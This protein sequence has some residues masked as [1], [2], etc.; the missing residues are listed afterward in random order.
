MDIFQESRKWD[1]VEDSK[2]GWGLLVTG[3]SKVTQLM[4]SPIRA[5]WVGG[6]CFVLFCFLCQHQDDWEAFLSI[7]GWEV[8]L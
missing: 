4:A 8:M 3:S 1:K 2:T 7:P 5:M 6:F